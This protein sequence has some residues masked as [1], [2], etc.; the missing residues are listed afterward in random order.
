VRVAAAPLLV[1]LLL[2]G[3][4]GTGDSGPMSVGE[5][6]REASA[7]TV[8]AVRGTLVYEYGRAMLWVHGRLDPD[9]WQGGWPVQWKESVTLRGTVGGGNITLAR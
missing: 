7:D 3:C 9:G 2:A 6:S 5:A 1:V 4:G 8:V